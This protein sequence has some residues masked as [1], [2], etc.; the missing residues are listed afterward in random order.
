MAATDATPS[1]PPSLRTWAA[2][3]AVLLPLVLWLR[4]GQDAN[5]DLR[6]YH[7]Y[8]AH[9]WL[10][11]RLAADIAPAQVQSWHNPLL[12]VPLYALV[13][14]G[15]PGWVVGAWL[16]VPFVVALWCLL[17]LY[18]R[19]AGPGARRGGLVALAVLATTGAAAFPALGSSFNDAFV[20]AGVLGAWWLLLRRDAPGDADWAWAGAVLGAVVGLKL[21]AAI[22]ALGLG[23]AALVLGPPR[24]LPRRLGVLAGCGLL[25]FGVTFALW[26][27]TVFRLHGSPV[28]PYLNQW[29]AAPDALTQAHVD[30]RFRAQGVLDVLAVP[31]RLLHESRRYSETGLRDARLLLGLVAIGVL[32]WQARRGRRLALPG[33]ALGIFGGVAFVLWAWQSG[34]YRYL[35]PVEMLACLAL[36]LAVQ[37]VPRRA[38]VALAVA[39]LAVVAFTDH[40]NFGRTRF[41]SPMLALAWPALPKNSM[42]V[43]SSTEPLAYALI[44]A[45]DD[46]PAV[47]VSNNFMRPRQCTGL[48]E[49]AEKQVR[50]HE[51]RMFLLRTPT[52]V[53]DA[54]Q[55]LLASEYGLLVAGECQ[56][57]TG[58]FGP[59]SLCPLRR[60]GRPPI[61]V[62]AAPPDR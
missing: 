62:P 36:V 25:G 4:L 22:Y 14:G 35:L 9:A 27:G 21:T 15:Q 37:R 38:G 57:I 10:H 26:G 29:F 44:A 53:D 59:L 47:S 1:T 24:A 6:N 41:T 18:L 2:A 23:A 52:P 55:L 20:A 11:G 7:L 13:H 3:L 58:G 54:G 46:V 49:R 16:L 48:Q 28:F 50:T 17:Q 5:W 34:V 42:V 12:D 56:P 51:G 30:A 60:V 43:M 45:P 39:A 40:P 61:C 32:A 8:N 31:F 19:L 33:L